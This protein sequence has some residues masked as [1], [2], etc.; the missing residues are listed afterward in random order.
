[1]FNWLTILIGDVRQMMLNALEAFL[2]FFK[3]ET[4]API[5]FDSVA[6]VLTFI[7][8][9]GGSAFSDAVDDAFSAYAEPFMVTSLSVGSYYIDWFIPWS[10]FSTVLAFSVIAVAA[11]LSVR[12]TLWIYLKVWGS[13]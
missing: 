1:M 8:G 9:L 2:E 12:G 13:N 11:A 6:Y 10:Y 3:I 4:L 7:A 5:F